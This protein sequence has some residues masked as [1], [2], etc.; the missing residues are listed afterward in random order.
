MFSNALTWLKSVRKKDEVV[1]AMDNE[2]DH[3]RHPRY[4]ITLGGTL[5]YRDDEVPCRVRNM[6]ASGALIEV[7]TYIRPGYLVTIDIPGIGKKTAN[8]VRMDWR[9]AAVSLMGDEKEVE[10]FIIEWQ[11]NQPKDTPSS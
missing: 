2:T 5:R 10:S 1:K 8:V 4:D 9:L 7:E 3:R 11:K 6:S